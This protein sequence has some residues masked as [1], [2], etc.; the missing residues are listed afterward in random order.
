MI[1]C[2]EGAL[3][4]FLEVAG[5]SS[6]SL[7]F[8]KT[9]GYWDKFCSHQSEISL[10]LVGEQSNIHIATDTTMMSNFQFH[11]NGYLW[12]SYVQ[13]KSSYK[14]CKFTILPTNY[15]M[16]FGT[17]SKAFPV[18][19]LLWI[20]FKRVFT[21]W[22]IITNRLSP[23]AF[24]SLPPY[25]TTHGKTSSLSSAS[26]NLII[27]YLQFFGELACLFLEFRIWGRRHPSEHQLF[28]HRAE[29]RQDPAAEFLE[30]ATRNEKPLVSIWMKLLGH[31]HKQAWALFVVSLSQTWNIC[32]R[33]FRKSP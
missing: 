1:D 26:N 2:L 13:K 22:R 20:P 7:S 32:P 21:S 8:W 5:C 12:D 28:M 23:W 17:S 10:V 31:H 4:F 11:K 6:S 24:A 14:M 25:F 19:E 18:M 29:F 16:V 33:A 3:G 27:N 15:Y 9:V 30:I